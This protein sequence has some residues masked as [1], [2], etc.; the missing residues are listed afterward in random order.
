MF[1]KICSII[2]QKFGTE[3]VDVLK[4]D[5]TDED[6]FSL[7]YNIVSEKMPISLSNVCLRKKMKRCIGIF[8]I[9]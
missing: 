7:V 5:I 2:E 3:Q 8:G 9:M 6:S 4:K 1:E